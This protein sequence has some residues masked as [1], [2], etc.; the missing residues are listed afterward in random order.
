MC[1]ET[2]VLHKLFWGKILRNLEKKSNFWQY[3]SFFSLP[4]KIFASKNFQNFQ[5]VRKILKVS[6]QLLVYPYVI[7]TPE[8]RSLLVTKIINF[9]IFSKNSKIENFLCKQNFL[10]INQ[11]IKM[12]CECFYGF[13]IRIKL[14]R[15]TFSFKWFRNRTSHFW[16]CP[17][18]FSI[19]PIRGSLFVFITGI[20]RLD[21]R[22]ADF[23][24]TVRTSDRDRC[25]A[26]LRSP[27]R[28]SLCC[29]P[30]DILCRDSTGESFC[31]RFLLLF[32]RSRYCFKSGVVISRP[33]R[34]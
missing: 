5:N 32:R 29:V 8:W 13:Y 15:V 26:P 4:R 1:F 11:N 31:T 27:S 14:P 16:I 34:A 12:I 30:F 25:R 20:W 23:P 7:I 6:P 10:L 22:T 18:D 9:L 24:K 17:R 19:W 28:P 21:L 2:L 33:R 3:S